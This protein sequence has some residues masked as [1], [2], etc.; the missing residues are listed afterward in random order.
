MKNSGLAILLSLCLY[1]TLS[2]QIPH[3]QHYSLLGKKNKV[4]INKI[5]QDSKGYLWFATDQGVF[6]FDGKEYN[7]YDLSDSLPDINVTAIA[8]D[9]IGRMW[10]GHNHGMISILTNGKISLFET[11]EGNATA[12]ISDIL[13][14]R[15]GVLWFG[16]FND[17]LYYYRGQRLYRVDEAD[18]LPDIYVYD[19]AE[20]LNGNILVGTD[21]GLSICSFKDGKVSVKVIDSRSGMPDNIVKKIHPVSATEILVATED[22][23]IVSINLASGKVET[24]PE[25]TYG[26]IAD[27]VVKNNQLW[28]ASPTNGLVVLDHANNR[29]QSF[30]H[31]RHGK[32]GSLKC[33]A[34]DSENNIWVG[35]KTSLMR[36]PGSNI[37]TILPTGEKENV[38]AVTV[39]H[40]GDIWYSTHRGLFIKKRDGSIYNPV[41]ETAFE[42]ST[43]ISLFADDA[44]YVWAGLYGEGALRIDKKKKKIRSFTKEL[45]NGNI[46]NITGRGDVIWL[47][48]LGG[49][50]KMRMVGEKAVIETF[51]T[52]EGLSSDFIYQ[53]FI[54]KEGNVW[55]ATDGKGIDR[56]GN[57]GLQHFEHGLPSKVIYSITQSSDSR[58]WVNVE[59]FGLRV[60]DGVD[61]FIE[62][63][64]SYQL[65]SKDIQLLTSDADGNIV[66]MDE[67]GVK[68]LDIQEKRAL[69]ISEEAG[70]A[71]MTPNLNA[72][73]R[74]RNGHLYFGTS[75]GIIQYQSGNDFIASKPR[76]Y[77]DKLKIYDTFKNPQEAVSLKY[78]EDNISFHYIGIWFKNPQHVYYAYQLENYDREWINT[79]DTEVTYSKLPPGKYVFKL[80]VSLTDDFH[81]YEETSFA[82]EIHPPFWM[83]TAF[84][85]FAICTSALF[86]YGI[87]KYRE[88]KLKHDNM[89]LEAKVQRR[90]IEIQNQA[91]EIQAQNEEIMAQAEEI[92]G[93]NENLEMLVHQ[94]TAE[95]ERKNRALEEYAF[96]NAHKL[97]SPVASVLGLIH[98]LSRVE[99]SHDANEIRR[100]LEQSATELDDIVRSITKAI[101]RGEEHDLFTEKDPEK[102]TPPKP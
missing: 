35:S 42:R 7:H 96:I 48:T 53:S 78:N 72:F 82:F 44:G 27:F 13:F 15:N 94:R 49:A 23:G 88:R 5:V 11:E 50:V 76:A 24:L 26:S 10:F 77:I 91:N 58:I 18:N 45:R 62:P 60:F 41:S 80:R 8:E 39:D 69:S 28:I 63:G 98:L 46:L 74:D 12:P 92:K 79:K 25:W 37:Q 65:I 47:S 61:K 54:D 68:I 90:T 55:F 57:N 36:T 52:E 56:L 33:L 32:L 6:R 101:E 9:S 16:T 66:F 29:V 20:D 59:G 38:L 3:F 71:E 93:I 95:L 64:F 43:V 1:G 86:G 99:L 81:D 19:I 97:R 87:I 70:L 21:G 4:E 67:T 31:D 85:V 102:S 2:A 100:R 83:T 34:L 75:S 17:A 89:L 51:S 40:D 30:D 14:D 84:F 22:A 73:G